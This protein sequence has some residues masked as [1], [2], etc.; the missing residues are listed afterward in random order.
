METAAKTIP[1]AI[2]AQS[3]ISRKVYGLAKG[4]YTSVYQTVPIPTRLLSMHAANRQMT[5]ILQAHNPEVKRTK[6]RGL[7]RK[8]SAEEGTTFQET[9]I[10]LGSIF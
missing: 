3:R 7:F 8:Y 4:G 2:V 5:G 6:K 1:A 9:M 10:A